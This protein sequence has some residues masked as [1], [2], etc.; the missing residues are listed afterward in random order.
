MFS[1][2][3][4]KE[5]RSPNHYPCNRSIYLHQISTSL[6]PTGCNMK[7]IIGLPHDC[8]KRSVSKEVGRA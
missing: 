6:G 4:K 8:G 7:S 2:Q 1:G 5:I 3:E